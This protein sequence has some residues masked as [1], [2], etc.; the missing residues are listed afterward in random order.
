MVL[1][2]R[3]IQDVPGFG[4]PIFLQQ[5]RG[6]AFILFLPSYSLLAFSLADAPSLPGTGS[7]SSVCLGHHPFRII[8]KQERM[9]VFP[10]NLVSLG[11]MRGD[12]Q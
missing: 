3:T 5:A 8:S 4:S 9:G 6:S 2:W 11:V 1:L 10:L 12:P 7:A